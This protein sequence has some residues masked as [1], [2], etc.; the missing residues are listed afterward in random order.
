[1]LKKLHIKNLAIIDELE[2]E[3]NPNLNILTGE[4]GSGKSIIINAISLLLGGKA[5]PEIVRSGSDTAIVEG[6]FFIEGTRHIVR[7][8]IRANGTSRAFLDDEP[9]K[10]AML[11]SETRNYVDLHGQHDHQLLLKA[12]THVDFLDAYAGILADRQILADTYDHLRSAT[13]EIKTLENQRQANKSELELKGQQLA[14]LEA[15][16][17]DIEEE[18][19][20]TSEH[21]LLSKAEELRAALTT[22]DQRFTSDDLS[23]SGA[24]TDVARQIA[25]FADISP[26]LAALNDRV[27]SVK[28]DLTELAFDISRYGDT[29]VSDP[30][31]LAELD[32]RIGQMET[33]KRKYGGSVESA[34]HTLD[35]LREAVGDYSNSDSRLTVLR[36][37]HERLQSA[38]SSQCK[39]IS[40]QRLMARGPLSQEI[41][42]DLAS[43]DMPGTQFEVR[44]DHVVD[45]EGLCKIDG[46]QFAGDGRGYDRVEFFISPNRGEEVRPLAKV[47]SGG[48]ISRTMLG[49][50]TVLAEYDQVHSLVFDEIDTGISGATA[51]A[52]GEALEK[53]AISRQVICITHLPQ[54]AACDSRHLTVTK[55]FND[56]RTRVRI[57]PVSEANRQ[58]EIARLLSGTDITAAGMAQA[59]ELLNQ[60]K[61]RSQGVSTGSIING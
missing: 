4:T 11:E 36:E 17:L 33:V 14:E 13:K 38:Y 23:L 9:L 40:Q 22:I 35:Q 19:A 52:V 10:L 48:E 59:A 30:N 50:K 49:I 54:I 43:L 21:K 16:N 42:N 44:I 6:E 51:G 32:E 2:V 3:F 39:S 26:E 56:G 53:L 1:M 55:Q 37:E 5:S 45:S 12:G 31:R 58:T 27:Q 34:L 61:A 18:I 46:E 60:A 57:Q 7:R 47:A 29:V 24:I 25:N 8:V 28:V 41:V 20:I 15:A